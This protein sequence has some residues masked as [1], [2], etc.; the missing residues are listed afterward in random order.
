MSLHGALFFSTE[1]LSPGKKGL[2]ASILADPGDFWT[3]L[4]RPTCL[5]PGDAHAQEL[6]D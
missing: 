6:G 4:A 5:R 1:D 2:E 3:S